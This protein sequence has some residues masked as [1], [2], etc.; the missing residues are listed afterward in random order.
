[1]I[2][3]FSFIEENKGRGKRAAAPTEKVW[4]WHDFFFNLDDLSIEHLKIPYP[5][6][7]QSFG[8]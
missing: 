3:T 4:P 7:K 1:M 2:Y 8:A 5:L 6:L